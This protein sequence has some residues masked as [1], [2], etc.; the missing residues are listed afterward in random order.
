MLPILAIDFPFVIELCE[1]A[2]LVAFCILPGAYRL[3]PVAYYLLP[4]AYYLLPRADC[5]LPISFC[6]LSPAY[7]LS[8]VASTAGLPPPLFSRVGT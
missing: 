3:L 6:L 2:V 8:P 1:R 5:L 4:V 7:R